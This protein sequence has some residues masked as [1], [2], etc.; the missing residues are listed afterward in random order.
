MP[1]PAIESLRWRNLGSGRFASGLDHTSPGR[2]GRAK[3]TMPLKLRIGSGHR[4]GRGN[5]SSTNYLRLPSFP[6]T[7]SGLG[8]GFD[9]VEVLAVALAQTY[10]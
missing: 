10:S 1:L 7:D 8:F 2:N 5:V 4:K 3:E 9:L 6:D